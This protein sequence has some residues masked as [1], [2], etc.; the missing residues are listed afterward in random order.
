MLQSMGS[1]RVGH[2]LVTQQNNSKAKYFLKIIIPHKLYV[3][4]QKKGFF[5]LPFLYNYPCGFIH[6]FSS[7][8]ST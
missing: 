7:A 3:K 5:S 8:V 1:Q 4:V 6:L 2:N